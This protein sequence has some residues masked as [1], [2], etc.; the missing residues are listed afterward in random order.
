VI[1]ALLCLLPPSCDRA[2]PPIAPA[3]VAS[4]SP[5]TE[6]PPSTDT[7]APLGTRKAGSDWPGFLGPFGTSVS[8]EN[9][10]LTT[11]PAKGLR[12]VWQT[13][14]GEGYSAPAIAN[15]RL[16]HFNRYG[17][18]ARVTCRN[19]ETGAELWR[20]EY[21]TDYRD[22]Y[23]YD[24]GPRC[25]PVV[26][27]DRVYLH[28]A[29][30]MLH[31]VK[32]DDGKLL[33]K[34]DTQAEYSFVQNFFGVGSTPVVEGDVLIVPV[35]GSPK[36]PEPDDF[37]QLKGNGSGIVAF[38][39]LT[40]K[41]K[42]RATDE[43]ASFS[44]PVVT[45]INGRSWGFYW[46]RNHLVGFEP[47]SGKVDFLFPWRSRLLESAIAANPVVIGDQVLLTECYGQGS[48]LLRVKPGG[49]EVVWADDP[50]A[51]RKRLECHWNTPIHVDGYVYGCSGRHENTAELRCVELATGNVKWVAGRE[52]GR[53][54]L[55]L[56]DGHFVILTEFGQL[57]LVKVNPTKYE[58]V[59]RLDLVHGG[60]ALLRH[61]CWA[62]PVLSHGLLYLRGNHRLV[63]LELIPE[64]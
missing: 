54:S 31:C 36:G 26:D 35:G 5:I 38:D 53:A 8:P 3:A 10:I 13:E 52:L 56:V 64:K 34:V 2:K 51:R 47:A 7:T 30:G 61:P 57:L 37:R 24:G 45:T 60:R 63:C 25:C 33:W 58:E 11:W 15:G 21:P 43:L 19:A 55:L 27:G 29:E 48:A 14:V 41:E 28:G 59:A 39:K 12:L 62:A 17:N 9:G 1:C 32:A 22:R 16:F 50:N 40:G 20:F 18:Q 23:G 6:A 42:Y 49:Y 46:A 4:P 44:S